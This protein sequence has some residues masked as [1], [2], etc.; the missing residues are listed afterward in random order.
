MR[1]NSEIHEKALQRLKEARYFEDCLNAKLCPK[2]GKDLTASGRSFDYILNKQLV[3]LKCR[4]CSFSSA[5]Q[6]D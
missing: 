5:N 1:Y 2:C 4:V 6:L 3:L